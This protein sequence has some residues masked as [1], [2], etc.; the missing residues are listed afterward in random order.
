M[1][2][3]S[4]ATQDLHIFLFDDNNLESS[5][6]FL[7]DLIM[8]KK[9]TDVETWLVDI[10]SLN[11][12]DTASKTLSKLSLDLDDNMFWYLE[13]PDMSKLDLWEVYRIH[14]S[15]SLTIMSY[16]NWTPPGNLDIKTE[17]KWSRRRNLEVCSS[18]VL[19]LNVLGILLF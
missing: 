6:A 18:A 11:D 9:R 5:V 10:T 16:G 4:R 19:E 7:E 3:L 15:K 13:M 14:P 12:I 8:A 2:N 1:Q 17:E